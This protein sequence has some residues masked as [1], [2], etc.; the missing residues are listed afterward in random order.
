MAVTGAK[1]IIGSI[2]ETDKK[3]FESVRERAERLGVLDINF[4]RGDSSD[5]LDCYEQTLDLIEKNKA[6]LDQNAGEFESYYQKW[7]EETRYLSSSKMFENEYYKKI[8]SL[9]KDVV[10]AIISKLKESPTHLFVALNKI[11]GEDPV[12]REHWGKVKNMAEDWIAWWEQNKDAP[13]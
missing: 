13:A 8:I 2:S 11:T 10:P 4:S 12:K 3:R 9:G 6:M 1:R 7:D 5:A